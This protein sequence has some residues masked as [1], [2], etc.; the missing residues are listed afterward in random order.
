MEEGRGEGWTHHD[1]TPGEGDNNVL[2][3]I[4]SSTAQLAMP[5]YQ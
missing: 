4:A 2:L 5:L 1:P 3:P